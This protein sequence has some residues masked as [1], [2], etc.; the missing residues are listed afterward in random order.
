MY[1]VLHNWIEVM[2]EINTVATIWLS[3]CAK[4]DVV[5]DTHGQFVRFILL[6]L[7]VILLHT[8]KGILLHHCPRPVCIPLCCKATAIQKALLQPQTPLADSCP[9]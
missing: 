2:S 6:E 1:N 9:L 7:V 5:L 4:Y 8:R 3:T